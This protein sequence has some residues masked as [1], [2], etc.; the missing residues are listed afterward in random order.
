MSL[1]SAPN[2]SRLF[3]K[4]Y[5]SLPEILRLTARNI[6][7]HCPKCNASLPA[8]SRLTTERYFLFFF[9]VSGMEMLINHT[10]FCSTHHLL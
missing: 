8:Q 6:T 4:Y 9:Y 2:I 10:G 1:L 5:A 7:P 3:P